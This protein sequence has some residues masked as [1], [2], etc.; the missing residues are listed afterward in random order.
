MTADD[1]GTVVSGT[2]I[3]PLRRGVER[4]GR[5]AGAGVDA[6]TRSAIAQTFEHVL[7]RV[8]YA[9]MT[10]G[11]RVELLRDGPVAY[12]SM[13]DLIGRAQRQL[14]VE[15]YIVRSD[16][17]GH[18]F[19]DAL[20]AASRRGVRVRLLTDWIGS[21]G[22]PRRFMQELRRSGIDV[23]V[24]NRPAA[25]WLW[26]GTLPRD[27]RKLL[28]ADRE[29]GIIGGIGIG[30]EWS[31]DHRPVAGRIGIPYANVNQW[32]DTAVRIEG[33]A[34]ED[35]TRSF[36]RMWSR[37]I[38]PVDLDGPVE[39]VPPD[40]PREESTPALV[41]IVDG[42]PW[43]FRTARAFHLQTLTAQRS[44]WIADAYFMPSM[45][46]VEALIGAARDGV[47]VRLLVPSRND[48]SWML[49][50]TRRYYRRLLAGGVRI[51][52]WPGPMMH[53]KT[54]VVD[55]HLTRVGSTDFNPLGLALNYE[56][57]AVIEDEA[58]GRAAE[59]MFLDDLDASREVRPPARPR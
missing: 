22:I 29:T 48:H 18:A 46:E 32:R 11:N 7:R 27:H 49:A 12:G 30:Q 58:V 6:P 33:E 47:D 25:R 21:R 35:M 31:P 45:V 5:R 4:S 40:A 52:E 36:E 23:C 56:L 53:A 34:A 43:R 17:V 1:G 54:T 2:R 24:F 14:D 15:S 3:L 37:A 50:I 42:D 39:A 59:S 55:G 20:V 38:G 9:R 19:G 41:G 28:V 10:G 44:I 13:L 51:W 57:D 8:A 16:V 26:R